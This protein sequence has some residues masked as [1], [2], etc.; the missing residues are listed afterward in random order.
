MTLLAL[1]TIAAGIAC[2]LT[3]AWFLTR[4]LPQESRTIRGEAADGLLTEHAQHFPQLR[5]PL[6]G[7]DSP[8]V[9]RYASPKIAGHWRDDRRQVLEAFLLALGDDFARLAQLA[10]WANATL[11]KEVARQR[12][13]PL[14]LLLQF[15]AN[16]RLASLLLRM[17]SPVFTRRITLLSELLGNLSARTE[18]SIAPLVRLPA[19]EP[20]APLP[21]IPPD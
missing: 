14:S 9:K 18:A 16:Y 13:I 4:P 1:S 3:L 6:A 19:E 7:S 12:G 5:H 20:R 21:K 2:F 8:F 17:R 10:A 15:R 11:P